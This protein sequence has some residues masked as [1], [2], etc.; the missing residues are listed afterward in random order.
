MS[1][2]GVQQVAG[3]VPDLRGAFNAVA[4]TTYRT[5]DNVS[6]RTTAT[7]PPGSG[8]GI[9]R[10]AA[11]AVI[12]QIENEPVGPR[13]NRL[14]FLTNYNGLMFVPD[15]WTD[16]PHL[17]GQPPIARIPMCASTVASTAT[18]GTAPPPPPG[19]ASVYYSG[20]G[21]AGTNYARQGN[22]SFIMSDNGNDGPDWS[23]G[24]CNPAQAANYPQGVNGRV[25]TTLSGWSLG[26]LG[27]IYALKTSQWSFNNSRYVLMFDP[28]FY[29]Q[30]TCDRQAGA[31]EV[32]AD[33]LGSNPA[34][35]LVIMAGE[36]TKP[37]G[38]EGIQLSYF[39]EI[40]R[41][42]LNSRVLVCNVENNGIPWSHEDVIKGYNWMISQPPPGTCP[43]GFLG[44]HP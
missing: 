20:K 17:A 35:R 34:N 8:Y 22:A 37:K 7:A 43:S 1:A 15:T 25:V 2:N 38:H 44:W 39:P 24:N 36:K 11:F 41:R 29:D 21:T 13:G 27:P 23:A 40:K 12:C 28:G 6:R 33:W 3:S 10:G 19:G 14:Y 16:S 4:G 42:G 32:L 31:A 18:P 26:R 30:M 5:I 9:P